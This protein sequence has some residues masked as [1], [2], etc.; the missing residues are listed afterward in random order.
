MKKY[1]PFS[2]I[3]PMLL[4]SALGFSQQKVVETLPINSNVKE[5]I[6][7]CKTHFDIGYTHRV[8]DLM[9]YYRTTMIDKALDVMESTS[10]LPKEQQFVWTAPGWVVAKVL[11]DW[12]GQTPERRKRIEEAF[13][14]GRIV[15]HA[16][17][18]TLESES[19]FPEVIAR[20]YDFSKFVCEAY[21]LPMPRDAKMTDVPS[22]GSILA[23]VLA[24]GNV[25]VVHLGCNWPSG[26][27]RYPN[28]FWW[29]GPDGSRVLTIYS[30]TY[31]TT[32]GRLTPAVWNNHFPEDRTIGKDLIP[33]SD[34]PYSIWPAVMVTGD[35]SGPPNA[36]DITAMFEEANR[37][38]PNVKI[39]MGTLGDFAD[40]ILATH[41][42][43]PVIKQEAPDTWIHGYGCD[44]GGMKTL[45]NIQPMMPAAEVFNTQLSAWGVAPTIASADISKAYEQCLLYAEHTWG[46]AS[47]VNEYGDKFKNLPPDKFKDLEG[48]WED[49]TDYIRTSDKIIRNLL[50]NDLNTLATNVN[51]NE[52]RFVVYN[53]LPWSR[54]EW[55]KAPD[56]DVYF[57]ANDIP[58]SGYKT[59]IYDD[60]KDTLKQ[61]TD[62]KQI[63]NTI[64]NEFYK[65]IFDPIK[66]SISSLIDKQSGREWADNS[67]KTGLGQYMNE[68][69]TFEQTLEYTQ[70]YQQGRAVNSFGTD[71]DWPHPGMYKPGMISA[72]E[73]PYRSAT[74]RN[75]SLKIINNPHCQVMIIEYPPDVANHLPASMLT[76][77]LQNGMPYLDMEMTIKGKEKDNWPEADWFC[78]PFKMTQPTFTVGRTLGVMNP[79]TDIMYGANRKLYAVGAGVSMTDVDGSGVTVCPIDHPLVSLGEPGIWKFSFDY[80]PQKP[81]VYINLYNNQWNTNFRYWYPGSF[82]S[83]V[84]IW[85]FDKNCTPENAL[86]VPSFEARTPLLIAKA[87]GKAGKL[88]MIQTGISLSRKGIEVTAFKPVNEKQTLLRV[89]E[90]A[91]VSDTCIVTLPVNVNVTT[92]VPVN[93]RY[94]KIGDPIAISNN[95]FTFRINKY[96][97]KSFLIYNSGLKTE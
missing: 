52:K 50:K 15:T 61:K 71:G 88:P 62:K 64:E 53:P 13:K 19:V 96:E 47:S 23:T 16:I 92:A 3:V 28:L 22:Q 36:E 77:T 84:R 17:P 6:V 73:I 60:I 72:K 31:G 67:C 55:V 76:I 20:G 94:E 1:I 41:P 86:Q 70:Q 26:Y 78:F 82:S 66:G 83:R 79:L 87:E 18:F 95:Q 46:G 58:A 56:E 34:W 24:Q 4:L 57:M 68:R 90:Q 45:R 2:L 97:P 39:R 49:K 33:P 25:K 51:C 75:G 38:I 80:V 14:S 93:L 10:S 8:K 43:I 29:E 59:F 35:N 65:V 21:N 48:S 7:I 5:I 74:S 37:L 54:S 27:V 32:V 30:H 44:P 9:E 11:E 63:A 42:N 12:D 69:F 81:V 89:W 85:T 40:A 91:G